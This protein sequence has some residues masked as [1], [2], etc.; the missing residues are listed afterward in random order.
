MKLSQKLFR[1]EHLS[2]FFDVPA[3]CICTPLQRPE[4]H[5][6]SI[7]YIRR[8]VILY[9]VVFILEQTRQEDGH[10]LW[11]LLVNI[12]IILPVLPWFFSKIIS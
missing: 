9:F 7:S 11:E 8:N 6:L 10:Q 1:V 2:E 4:R 3:G 5:L 12:F